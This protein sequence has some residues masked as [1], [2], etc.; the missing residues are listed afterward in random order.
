MA[1]AQP[2]SKSLSLHQLPAAV[3]KTVQAEL[4]SAKLVKIEKDEEEGE[5]SFTV[6]KASK[7]GE[8]YFTVS[9]DGIL[10]NTEVSLAETPPPVQ[11]TIKIQLGQGTLESIEKSF[12]DSEISYDIEMK[13]KAGAERSF[14]V[15]PDGKLTSAQIGLEEIPGP[16]RKTIEAHVGNGKLGDVY[17]LFDGAEVFYDAEVHQNGKVRD[18]IAAPGGKLESIQVFLHETPAHVQKTIKEKLG[19]G[20]LIRIDE[21]F[22]P[23]GTVEAYEVEGRKDGK[24]FNFSVGPKGHFLG[25]D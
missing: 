14:S 13:T 19:N 3:Q 17:R 10:L 7:D 5:V 2:A 11:N 12:E 4:G 23:K 21:S 9:G 8:R 25:M 18:V 20:R 16:A 22:S 15:A 1:S 24:P 6:T